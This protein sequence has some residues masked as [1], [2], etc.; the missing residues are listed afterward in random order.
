[1]VSKEASKYE[2][3]DQGSIM[4][5]VNDEGG[6]DE[7][8]Y[9]SD[10][11]SR[12]DMSL[13]LQ[14]RIRARALTTVP[15]SMLQ[16]FMLA[17]Q[18]ARRDQTGSSRF[19][20]IFLDF[21]STC[22]RQCTDNDFEKW[23][24]RSGDKHDCS[25]GNKQW[26]RRRK[27]DA[28]CYV[29]HKFDDPVEHEE[30]C[31]CTNEDYECDYNFIRNGDQCLPAGPEPIPADVCRDASGTYMGSSGYRLIP[32]NTC[33][34]SRGIVKDAKV[35]KDRSLAQPEEG[36]LFPD[37]RFIVFYLHSHSNDRA[38]IL[39]SSQKYYY[40]TD[41]GRSWKPLYAPLL[42][43]SFGAT[44]CE[45]SAEKC[46]A[47]A[48][49]S[50]DNGRNWRFVEELQ[51][52]GGAQ[53]FS[54][55]VLFD[56]VIG[57]AKFSEF[58]IVAEYL[59]ERQ[60]LDLQVS[61][62]GKNFATGVFPSTL[63]PQKHTYTILQSSTKSVFMHLTTS[64][65]PSPYWGVVKKSNGNGT[66]SVPGLLM[67]VRNVGETLAPYMLWEFGDSVSILVIASDK[68]PIDRVLFSTDESI[69]WCKIHAFSIKAIQSMT[70]LS[71]GVLRKSVRK[72]VFLV[73]EA[74]WLKE[75]LCAKEKGQN[76]LAFASLPQLGDTEACVN[77]LMKTECAP[78]A[79]LVARTYE[80]SLARKAVDA[81]RVE[82]TSKDRKKLAAAARRTWITHWFLVFI[83]VFIVASSLHLLEVV[84]NASVI[85][86]HSMALLEE[87]DS[88]SIGSAGVKK[89]K[90]KPSA[91]AERPASK[92]KATTANQSDS[93]EAEKDGED[94]DWEDEEEEE[95]EIEAVIDAKR[96]G[97][98]HG[99]YDYLV[100][101][102]GY[103]SK[104]NSWVSEKDAG[105]AKDLIDEY[106]KEN[107]KSTSASRPSPRRRASMSA[108][109]S[110]ISAK[111][112][113]KEKSKG[114]SPVAKNTS[115]SVMKRGRGKGPGKAAS[116]SAEMERHGK[117]KY[118][119]MKNLDLSALKNW[120]RY[121]KQVTTAELVDEGLMI[122]FK[123]TDNKLILASNRGTLMELGIS[124][125]DTSSVIMQLL[126]G[127]NLIDIDFSL[128]RTDIFRWRAEAR[129]G[130]GLGSSIS[131]SIA[132]KGNLSSG[133]HSCQQ[134]STPVVVQSS[135]M[136]PS[137][138]STSFSGPHDYAKQLKD[139]QM[140]TAGHRKGSMYKE[141][142]H[143]IPTAAAF[144][145]AILGL[146]S[147]AANFMGATGSGIG[148]LMAV[149][150]IYSLMMVG[151][152]EQQEKQP[153]P[154][155]QE[156]HEQE[157]EQAGPTVQGLRLLGEE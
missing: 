142:K 149:T 145:Y 10:L 39:T 116:A 65:F 89:P 93:E 35:Q 71:T 148:I 154:E 124:P 85:A 62:D 80:P 131:L 46:L 121:V 38:Y 118:R 150:I 111:V 67:A 143:V 60:S 151:V 11:G 59:Q 56:R 77:L 108:K 114:A 130:Y 28:D 140:V 152:V 9:S 48:R 78:Q 55:K 87:A 119:M 49:Y 129:K 3:G 25:M 101:W 141:L 41:A 73:D 153:E 99:E 90:S 18:L 14:Y 43:N 20:V 144:G 105:N 66:P 110:S 134:Q 139:Q 52:V 103:D 127:A 47:E 120:E 21:A 30:N 17:G 57:F 37:E 31:P 133:R 7:V 13:K 2:F 132:T 12:A 104:Y 68:E 109:S 157:Q 83:V 22:S 40:T 69:T 91:A 100:K 23:Y 6:V 74:V 58:L 50:T 117:R 51:L 106:F 64:E 70:T 92:S 126:A 45:G 136:P 1:M 15:D 8:R 63:R 32:G 97:S 72:D 54:K 53:F 34:K 5:L 86:E 156:W 122:Y 61:L 107:K 88:D 26:Y 155:S 115:A 36:E 82:L 125:I 95:Y 102:K 113:L 16:K 94:G 4:V 24:A 146:L 128:K 147:V 81:W 76:N 98:K 19:V 79:V 44:D 84:H 135:R 112:T 33:D 138:S 27:P 29:G 42:P 75:P 137:R 123:T 96:G